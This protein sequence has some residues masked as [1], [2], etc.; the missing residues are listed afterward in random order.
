ML[1]YHFYK[2]TDEVDL[3]LQKHADAI[4][5]HIGVNGIPFGNAQC[6]ALN[7]YADNLDTMQWLNAL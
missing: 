5:C 2:N 3:Y 4:Q 1:Y 6:P 7:D